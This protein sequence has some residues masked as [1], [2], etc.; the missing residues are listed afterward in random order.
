MD[1]TGP[2]QVRR[3]VSY[4]R[5][6]FAEL[7]YDIVEMA[8][9]PDRVWVRYHASGIHKGNAWGFEPTGKRAEYEG[10][11]ILYISPEGKIADRWGA[12]CFYDIFHSLGLVPAWWE[13][14]KTLKDFQVP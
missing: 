13:L 14:G 12:F 10:A 8:V 9:L 1:V 11:T 4:L 7:R 5:T 2:A 3:E 6:V